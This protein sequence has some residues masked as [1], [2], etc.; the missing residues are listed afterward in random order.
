MSDSFLTSMQKLSF[1][2]NQRGNVKT[3]GQFKPKTPAK[4]KTGKNRQNVFNVSKF[5]SDSDDNMMQR[6]RGNRKQGKRSTNKIEQKSVDTLIPEDKSREK[7]QHELIR[8]ILAATCEDGVDIE[9]A[10]LQ[11][12]TAEIMASV[13]NTNQ[14][15]Y[16]LLTN[17]QGLTAATIFTRLTSFAEYGTITSKIGSIA[18]EYEIHS[19]EEEQ[20]EMDNSKFNKRSIE[21]KRQNKNQDR[22]RSSSE[23]TLDESNT[24]MLT[25]A[26]SLEVLNNQVSSMLSSIAVVE[27]TQR[28]FD[29]QLNSVIK[30]VEKLEVNHQ[31]DRN[32]LDLKFLTNSNEIVRNEVLS[33]SRESRANSEKMSQVI[34]MLSIITN[35]F[36]DNND[37][38]DDTSEEEDD[39][40]H[41]TGG[42]NN[43]SGEET[44]TA[45]FFDIDND[46]ND[47]NKGKPEEKTL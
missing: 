37:N 7:Y 28:K 5:S 36:C 43:I 39:S 16:D 31:Q 29:S 9:N 11:Q 42:N 23:M 32:D 6:K 10:S 22:K 26:N 25:L 27:K 33:L 12:T 17:D 18:S 13:C 24:L 14:E 34:T 8:L 38:D 4:N 35:N 2:N 47:N 40:F 15:I 1:S 46:E 21:T 30:R 45:D 19:D 3:A 20:H 41:I 44:K